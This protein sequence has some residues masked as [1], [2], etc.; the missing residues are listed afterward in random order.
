MLGACVEEAGVSG[1]VCE[2]HA[3]AT[4]PIEIE[5]SRVSCLMSF[6]PTRYI[7]PLDLH[8]QLGRMHNVQSSPTKLIFMLASPM[9]CQRNHRGA[10]RDHCQDHFP[11][12]SH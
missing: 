10:N 11:A 1:A 6:A 3:S 9:R 8:I 2:L 12:R 5:T 4:A 7:K